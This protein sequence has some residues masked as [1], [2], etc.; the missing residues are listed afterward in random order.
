MSYNTCPFLALRLR[1]SLQHVSVPCTTGLHRAYNTCP[2]LSLGAYTVPTTRV[3]FWHYGN[4]QSIQHV[5]FPV[6]NRLTRSLQ[7]LSVTCNTGLQTAYKRPF[8]ALQACK[9]PTT[10]DRSLH[11]GLTQSLQHVPV[12]CTCLLYTSPSPRDRTTSRMPSS[13]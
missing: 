10:R 9:D 5:S 8:F 7:H 13:A 12:P 1:Q 2:F 11:Y 3:R 4:T 6:R